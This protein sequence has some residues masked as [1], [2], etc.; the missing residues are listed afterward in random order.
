MKTCPLFLIGDLVLTMLAAGGLLLH[1]R[2]LPADLE[3]ERAPGDTRIL[4]LLLWLASLSILA[5]LVF[6]FGRR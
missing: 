1:R 3:T 2:K 4:Y 6:A 5:Y